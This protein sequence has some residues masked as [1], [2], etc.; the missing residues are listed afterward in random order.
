[1]LIH[2]VSLPT[3][4]HLETDGFSTGWKVLKP[5][6]FEPWWEFLHSSR[7]LVW[8]S[9]YFD[10]N[11]KPIKLSEV[12][13]IGSCFMVPVWFHLGLWTTPCVPSLDNL[14]TRFTVVRN[15]ALYIRV[16]EHWLLPHSRKIMSCFFILQRCY[17]FHKFFLSYI[18]IYIYNSSCSWSFF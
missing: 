13:Y 12:R 4:S 6:K 9:P 5:S 17:D 10:P 18:Y 16:R 3:N 8:N 7:F 15:V 14:H 2:V 1:M 11:M